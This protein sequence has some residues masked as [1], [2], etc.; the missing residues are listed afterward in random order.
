MV[1]RRKTRKF[2]LV[3]KLKG[4]FCEIVFSPGNVPLYDNRP[5]NAH[6]HVYVHVHVHVCIIEYQF[7]T[8]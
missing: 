3:N 1:S 4:D 6:I 8:Q 5:I 2:F 7:Q